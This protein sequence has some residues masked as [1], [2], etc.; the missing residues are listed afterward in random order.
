MAKDEKKI[1][2]EGG[3]WAKEQYS[4]AEI[5]NTESYELFKRCGVSLLLIRNKASR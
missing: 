2:Q 5:S 4:H 1:P 3:R